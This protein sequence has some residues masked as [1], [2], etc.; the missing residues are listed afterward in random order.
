MKLKAVVSNDTDSK[1]ISGDFVMAYVASFTKDDAEKTIEADNDLIV[2]G[3]I[4][5]HLVAKCLSEM[6]FITTGQQAKGNALKTASC[7]SATAKLL[8][9]KSDELCAEQVTPNEVRDALAE[10]FAAGECPDAKGSN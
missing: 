5:E 6:I 4:P 1:E 3:K 8:I 9:Q 2:C 10:L 7:L